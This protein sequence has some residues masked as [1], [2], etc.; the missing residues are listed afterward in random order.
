MKDKTHSGKPRFPD[1]EARIREGRYARRG[2]KPRPN[3]GPPPSTLELATLAATLARS[4]AEEIQEK[5][6][7]SAL[8]LWQTAQ[9]TLAL[10]SQCN[11]DYDSLTEW[12]KS[13]QAKLPEPP[14]NQ[15][16]PMRLDTFCRIILPDLN[17]GDR[18]NVIKGWLNSLPDGVS[19]GKMNGEPIERARFYYLRDSILP[20]YA[21]WKSAD[22]IA[23]KKLA[24]DTRWQKAAKK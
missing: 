20:W 6:C 1:F 11:A 7:A 23:K 17:S 15:N 10:Q 2:L 5:L 8:N 18:D 3:F 9:E 14:R 21:K 22:T 16:W 12:Q 4:S 19:F 13:E 24:A